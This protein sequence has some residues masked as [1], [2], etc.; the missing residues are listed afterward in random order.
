MN[1]IIDNGRGEGGWQENVIIG[2]LGQ[3]N[4]G[5]LL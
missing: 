4:G 1:K 2:E 3:E 5:K